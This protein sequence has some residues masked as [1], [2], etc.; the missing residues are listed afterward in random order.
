MTLGW[1]RDRRAEAVARKDGVPLSKAILD[2][3]DKHPAEE[4]QGRMTDTTEVLA[5]LPNLQNKI[6]EVHSRLHFN[7]DYL[8]NTTKMLATN[9]PA[10]VHRQAFVHEATKKIA[11]ACNNLDEVLAILG[12]RPD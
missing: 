11:D 10:Y 2:V 6:N 1:L 4:R 12:P 3:L 9:T 5:L 7:F 8:H